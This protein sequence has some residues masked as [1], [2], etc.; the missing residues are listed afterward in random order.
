[1]FARYTLWLDD[2]PTSLTVSTY[3]ASVVATS[4]IIVNKKTSEISLFIK[5]LIIIVLISQPHFQPSLSTPLPPWWVAFRSF[6][7][8]ASISERGN[9]CFTGLWCQQGPCS[10]SVWL[11]W[12]IPWQ[13]PWFSCSLGSRVHLGSRTQWMRLA[14]TKV[15]GS[16]NSFNF[17]IINM[18]ETI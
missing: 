13:Q 16:D 9:C 4:I 10:A 6:Q 5:S 1:M 15:K 14:S 7:W 18:V 12:C 2:D 3:A 17:K 11:A 8:L